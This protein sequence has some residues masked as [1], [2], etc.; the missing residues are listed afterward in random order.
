MQPPGT[1]PTWQE[2]AWARAGRDA[3]ADVGR[4]DVSLLH[5]PADAFVN[6]G[7]NS[8]AGVQTT[9]AEVRQKLAA[10]LHHTLAAGLPSAIIQG[11]QAMASLPPHDQVALLQTL[12]PA[13]QRV[14]EIH[15]KEAFNAVMGAARAL[16]KEE[17]GVMALRQA[18]T[19]QHPG[20]AAEWMEAR[21]GK[22]AR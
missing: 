19:R 5:R 20:L 11:C 16:D 10:D 22:R 2:K 8:L 9:L 17:P 21:A 18:L 15:R 4:P 6:L 3:W 1:A 7:M 12:A 14:P 13:L